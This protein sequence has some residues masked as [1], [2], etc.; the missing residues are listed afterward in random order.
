MIQDSW[1]FID[2]EGFDLDVDLEYWIRL[3]L[4]QSLCEK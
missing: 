4:A 1:N 2:A 3:S